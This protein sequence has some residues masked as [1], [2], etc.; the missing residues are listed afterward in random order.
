MNTSLNILK[1]YWGHTSFRALQ[2][3]IIESVLQGKDTVAL[4]PTGGGK[5]ICFQVPALQL[6]GICIVI[7]PLIALMND[8]V[9]TLNKMGV[10]ALSLSGN[11]HYNDLDRL[12]DNCIYGNYKF[13]Y[14][15]PERLHQELVQLRIAKMNINLIAIDEAHCISQWG[16]DFRP[17]YK[18][19]LILRKLHPKVPF[20]ALTA[21]ATPEVLTDTIN[22]LEL[23]DPN[24]LQKSFY[25]ENLAY[26][27]LLEDDKLYRIE[28]LLDKNESAIIYTRNRKKTE[29][30]SKNLNSRGFKTSFYHGG[31]T[32]EEKGIRFHKWMQNITPIMV[33]TNAF[34]M[35]I[36]KSNVHT[37]IHFDLPE[38]LESY[39][40]EAGRAGRDDKYARAILLYNPS[41]E[42]QVKN[43]FL[44]NLPTPDYCKI[45]YRKLCNYLYIA[46]GEGEF[47]THPFHFEKFCQQYELH[48]IKTYNAIQALDRLGI[49]KLSIEFGRKTE[50]HFLVPTNVLLSYFDRNEKAS[51]I[52]KTILRI[53]SGIFEKP[54][55]INV[56]LIASKTNYT[57]TTVLDMLK[58]FEKDG[59]VHLQISITDATLTFVEPREDDRT[60]NRVSKL[61]VQQNE[62]KIKQVAS[63]LQYKNN[64]RLC[65]SEQL[66]HYFGENNTSPCGICSVC[67]KQESLPSKKESLLISQKILLLLEEEGALNSRDLSEKLSFTEPKIMHVL[68]LLLEHKKINFNTKNQYTLF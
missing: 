20:I 51:A 53:Y 35:G 64:D 67:A 49:I 33:A 37:V 12:L 58:Q 26:I 66:L 24:I 4:L 63:V 60:I 39:F 36:D 41:D 65:K 29:E 46:Y 27:T 40:Q 18:N 68:R 19:L 50:V 28:K 44:I 1:K 21:T 10:K 32:A 55:P 11:L 3:E 15:S 22:E 9:D 25:R 31:I 34:G 48:T 2:Q 6:E 7:S 13:L 56:E 42:I 59:I 57:S 8:Q 54:I 47:T 38:S 14:L 45:I 61:L 23:K 62:N 16:N 30:V 52:G 17:A 5:S 43:Q